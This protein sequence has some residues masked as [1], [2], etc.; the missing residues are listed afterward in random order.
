MTS[1]SGNKIQELL[2]AEGLDFTYTQTVDDLY[3][4]SSVV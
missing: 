4:R 3:E 2:W 1:L